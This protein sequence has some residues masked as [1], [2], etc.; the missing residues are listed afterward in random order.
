M[1]GK[2]RKFWKSAKNYLA[3]KMEKRQKAFVEDI[4]KT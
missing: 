2:S 3:G 1:N 4:S